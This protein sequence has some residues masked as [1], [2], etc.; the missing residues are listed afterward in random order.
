MSKLNAHHRRVRAVKNLK[1]S[2]LHSNPINIQ[3]AT[4]TRLLFVVAP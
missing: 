1:E 4:L 2:Y 3:E